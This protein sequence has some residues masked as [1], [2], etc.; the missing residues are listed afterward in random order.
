MLGIDAVSQFKRLSDGSKV[1]YRRT[2]YRIEHK[3]SKYDIELADVGDFYLD[4]TNDSKIYFKSEDGI[5]Y[6]GRLDG[7]GGELD[8]TSDTIYLPP[9]KP[10]KLAD[11]SALNLPS[12]I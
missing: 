10:Y 9:K 8:G 3:P 4:G 2:T 11:W 12:S 6:V 1:D 5:P 7:S